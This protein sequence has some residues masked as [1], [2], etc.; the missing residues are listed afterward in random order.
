MADENKI[1]K[2]IAVGAMM[3]TVIT[4]IVGLSPNGWI[5]KSWNNMFPSGGR[6][7]GNGATTRT[8]N[9]PMYD[10]KENKCVLRNNRG[11]EITIT[12]D[13]NNELFRRYCLQGYRQPYY[14][15]YVY[16]YPVKWWKNK[17]WNGHWDGNGD[18]NG[19]GAPANGA[20]AT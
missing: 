20:P 13:S 10:E 6:Y 19:N 17:K 18:D 8:A 15:N 3:F 1:W 12:S 14:Y 9:E 16:Y 4:I 11:E 5:R 2:A 7:A